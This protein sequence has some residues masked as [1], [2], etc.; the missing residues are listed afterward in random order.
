MALP[1]PAPLRLLQADL[2]ACPQALLDLQALMHDDDSALP[3]IAALI[4]SDMALAAA[5]VRTVNSAMYGLLRRVETV[6]E[7]LRYLGTR[8]VIAISYASALR[9][10]F[11]SS[12]RMNAL[13]E[14]A[15]Q[16]GLLMGRSARALGMDPLQAHT[17]GLFARSGLA[18]MLAHLGTPHAALVDRWS[19]DPVALDAA[20]TRTWGIGHAAYGSVLC[21]SWGLAAPVVSFVR[22]RTR[23]PEQRAGLDPR[24]RRLLALGSA[25]E[26]L[27]HAA[28]GGS[29][30]LTGLA[31]DDA[32]PEPEL[33]A[34]IAPH[35][36][37][38]RELRARGLQIID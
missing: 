13:W 21:A 35:W 1:L 8:E 17:A 31:G 12:P 19:H 20:E 32:L 37:P 25:A 36:H 34:A 11:P 28:A 22:E 30:T 16:T 10:A 4:E 14:A 7:A 18:V 26:A 24:L 27:L 15:G 3:A 9:S 2:P 38:L 6:G 29:A 23:P 33:R 5:V